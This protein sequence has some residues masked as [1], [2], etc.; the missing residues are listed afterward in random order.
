M[1]FYRL[2]KGSIEAMAPDSENLQS[3]GKFTVKV[4]QMELLKYAILKRVSCFKG[5]C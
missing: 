5:D 3:F 2:I 1:Q 4:L